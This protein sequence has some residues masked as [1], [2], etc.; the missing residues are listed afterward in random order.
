MLGTSQAREAYI[1]T[2]RR[3]AH[4]HRLRSIY[5]SR[6]CN[7]KRMEFRTLMAGRLPSDTSLLMVRG[8]TDRKSAASSGVSKR[9]GLWL[10]ISNSFIL[11]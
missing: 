3:G 10:V 4:D 5:I 11:N 7:L 8:E 2:T 6:S 1:W 9:I